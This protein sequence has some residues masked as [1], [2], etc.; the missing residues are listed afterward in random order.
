[1]EHTSSCIDDARATYASASQVEAVHVERLLADRVAETGVEVTCSLAERPMGLHRVT[2]LFAS[3]VPFGTMRVYAGCNLAESNKP[4]WAVKANGL[5][6][7]ARLLAVL[8]SELFG[9]MIF[10]LL[11][12]VAV[13]ET[14]VGWTLARNEMADQREKTLCW[15]IVAAAILGYVARRS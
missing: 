11:V 7:M 5:Q 14:K 4:F 9:W 13:Y 10:P 6:S 8:L 12:P 2:M 15:C 3:V 1:M